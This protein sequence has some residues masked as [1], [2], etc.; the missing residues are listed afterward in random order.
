[1]AY[2]PLLFDAIVRVM[3]E[4]RRH[5][6]AA[7]RDIGL[8][9]SRALVVTRLVQM[10]GATQAE[11]AAAIGVEPPTLKRQIDALVSDGFIERRAL[12][13]DARKKALFVTEKAKN[14]RI[15]ALF[16]HLGEDIVRDIPL[17]SQEKTRAVLDQIAEKMRLMEAE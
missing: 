1:M 3:R 2:D 12:N 15:S 4:V 10:E 5:Y 14:S 8:T 17:E 6:D 13:G 16:S 9:M 7:A 11:L